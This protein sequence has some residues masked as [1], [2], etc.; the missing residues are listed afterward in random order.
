MPNAARGRTGVAESLDIM[1]A[2]DSTDEMLLAVVRE[3]YPAIWNAPTGELERAFDSACEA[4]RAFEAGE[5]N[6][7]TVMD[8]V[9]ADHYVTMLRA[10]LRTRYR[11]G[12]GTPPLS[13]A[14]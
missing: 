3:E 1:E 6:R 8:Y 4:I 12:Q 13:K 9:E 14:A 5:A 7:P 11:Q 10:V 2:F